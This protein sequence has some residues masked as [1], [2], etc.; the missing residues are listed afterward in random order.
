[1]CRRIGRLPMDGIGRS[2]M[3]GRLPAA[4]QEVVDF[5]ELWGDEPDGEV[6]VVC[7]GYLPLEVQRR[8][9]IRDD[10]ERKEP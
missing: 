6:P 5:M 7:A 2:P 10:L 3:E 8:L 9:A 1:M 4:E